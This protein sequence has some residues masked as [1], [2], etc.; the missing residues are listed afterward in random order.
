MSTTL[1]TLAVKRTPVEN[2]AA[3]KSEANPEEGKQ[4]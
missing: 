1:P 4:S 3:G 2:E